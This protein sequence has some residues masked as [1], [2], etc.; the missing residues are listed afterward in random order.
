MIKT[1]LISAV[2]G[3]AVY[4]LLSGTQPDSKETVRYQ[5]RIVRQIVRVTTPNGTKET[6]NEIENRSGT[7]TKTEN[8]R[9]YFVGA[10]YGVGGYEAYQADVGVRVFKNVALKASYVRHMGHTAYLVGVQVDF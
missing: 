5:D 10:A 1:L 6:I 7:K 8:A 9:K 4:L 3:A 2:T